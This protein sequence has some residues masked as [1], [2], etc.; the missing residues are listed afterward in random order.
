MTIGKEI[1]LIVISVTLIIAVIIRQNRKKNKEKLRL[2]EIQKKSISAQEEK[3]RLEMI[4]N[5]KEMLI[6]KQLQIAKKFH[7]DLTFL[8]EQ[9]I[10]NSNKLHIQNE[11][12]DFFLS[13]IKD[14]SNQVIDHFI[15]M[16]TELDLNV[17]IYN[18][19]F[20]NKEIIK[21]Q[22]LLSDI[23]G[24]SLDEQQIVAV[25]T[26]EDNNLVLAG[27]GSGKT[28]TIAGKVKYLVK[29]KKVDP[30]DILLLSFTKKAAEEMR[31]RIVDKM[32]ID[33][34]SKTFHKLGLD[35][36]TQARGE[37]PEIAENLG[38][39]IKDYFEHHILKDRVTMGKVVTFFSYYLKIPPDYETFNN[40][41]EMYN[42]L[43]TTNLETIK[44][45]I[46]K[47]ISGLKK[48]KFTIAGEEVKSIEEA[49]IA[50]FLYLNGVEY[51]YEKLY[52]YPNP[53]R[54]RKAYK[55]DFHLPEYDLYLEHFG[56]T[57]DYRTPWLSS[58]EEQK[59]LDGIRWKRDFHTSNRTTLLETYSYFNKEGDI[60]VELKKLLIR[61]GV[62]LKPRN[63]EEI[64]LQIYFTK[65]KKNRDF[66]E[67]EKLIQTFIGL[68]KSK[69]YSEKDFTKIKTL[70]QKDTTHSFIRERQILLLSIIEN[71]YN[72]YQ[73]RLQSIGA[74][75]F[76]DMINIATDIVLSDEYKSTFYQ[77]IIIDEF[78]DI[79]FARY[80]LVKALRERNNTKVLSVGDDWQSIYRFAGSDLQL[81]AD[82][83]QYFGF[84]ELMKIERTYRNSQQLVDTAG[85]FMMKNKSQLPKSLRS[86]K[87]ML[88]PIQ[89]Y[90]YDRDFLLAFERAIQDIL[91]S[92]GRVGS[93]LI[94]GRN[95]YD[96]LKLEDN[97][98]NL[99]QIKKDKTKTFVIYKQ[100]PE[101]VIEFLTVHRSKGLEADNVIVIN[102]ENK[103]TGF[104]NTM[105][106][107]L[108]L[109]YVLT[110]PDM[111]PHSEERRL[112]YVAITRTRN[113]TYLLAPQNNSSI[114]IEELVKELKIPFQIV[115]D[116]ESILDHPHC[117]YCTTGKL[118]IRENKK[119]RTNFLGC[120]NYP[121]CS[122]SF[123]EISLLAN[124]VVCSQ[125]G[126]YMVKRKGSKGEF[127]GCTNF[128]Y[129]RSIINVDR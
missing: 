85:E 13:C 88:R 118:V 36:I 35:I 14:S 117:T 103:I 110:E 42:H 73:N 12:K 80:R 98:N 47:E 65:N 48:E 99:F 120:T 67:I 60:L 115:T 49:I 26:D 5:E 75:D 30:K 127:Y 71:I 11:Y 81:F 86:S 111:F 25:V 41:G 32:N 109:K 126:G 129:C 108:I 22:E 3:L 20:T 87:D 16:Y 1:L 82:F 18:K 107:D 72:L 24:K 95:N 96:V 6:Q 8:R 90:G 39:V 17:R 50:N 97:E 10:T 77:Y 23:D 56:I 66:G 78:Q 2:E 27:A 57:K 37:H 46:E 100:R 58:I 76:P 94:L 101:V 84:A 19:I 89:I 122:Q 29:A 128:P 31:E 4:R 33:V 83:E 79:S 51:S 40:I 113:K 70:I 106:D 102:L 64:Y 45:K 123:K 63:L 93:I 116:E 44:S 104:P 53:D 9:Y 21:N 112:F 105:S 28:L 69:G 43:K 121:T 52:P 119:D 92:S 91:N 54:F 68:F 7:A 74:I 124:S 62:V 55:P 34:E 61:N 59:Y 38:E 15:K 125:C 114:F